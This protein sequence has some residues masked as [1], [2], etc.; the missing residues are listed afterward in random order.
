MYRKR[1]PGNTGR[2]RSSRSAQST[3]SSSDTWRGSR[4]RSSHRHEQ[5]YWSPIPL[6]APAPTLTLNTRSILLA[7]S[8]TGRA[9]REWRPYFATRTTVPRCG[10]VRPQRNRAL[11]LPSLLYLA[12]ERRGRPVRLAVDPRRGQLALPLVAQLADGWPLL[13][14]GKRQSDCASHVLPCRH[15]RFAQRPR[16]RMEHDGGGATATVQRRSL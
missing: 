5:Y 4:A 16:C 6:Q 15:V 9:A 12:S 8:R 10:I 2:T 3:R 13:G 14:L 1:A 11:C 7:H